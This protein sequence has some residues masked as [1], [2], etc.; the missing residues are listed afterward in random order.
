MQTKRFFCAVLVTG[1]LFG[2]PGFSQAPAASGLKEDRLQILEFGIEILEL[3]RALRQEANADYQKQLVTVYRGSRNWELREQITGFFLDLK[4][5][6]LEKDAIRELAEPDKKPNGFLLTTVSYLTGIQS[7]TSETTFVD[8]MTNKNKTL[9]LASI[10][11]LAKLGAR[12]RADEILKIYQDSETDPNFKPDIIWALGEMKAKGAVAA[13]VKEYEDSES[14]PL[15]RGA[16]LQALG[17]IGDDKAWP[18]ISEAANSDNAELRAAAV[19]AFIS[20]PKKEELVSSLTNALRDAQVPVRLAGAE[21]AS[22]L[23]FPE[24][25]DLLM[26]RVRKDPEPRV[27]SASLRAVAAYDGAAEKILPL[28]ADRK[29]DFTVWRE[30]LSQAIEKKWVGTSAALKSVLEEENKEKNASL[31]PY[32]GTA[33]LQPRETYRELFGLLLLSDKATARGS[34]LRA[35]SAGNFREYETVVRTLAQKDAD[36]GVKNQ[37]NAILKDWGMKP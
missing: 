7:E 24:L 3:V 1:L 30:A 17:K 5:K 25:L 15:L 8:L 34:A 35:I 21:A 37:A 11:A 32:I 19:G 2:A 31:S 33:L 27:R 28:L 22:K 10:R 13:L 6:S 16:L 29:T 12:G 14:E 20:F 9:A 23:K 36:F 26:F 4:D 18:L